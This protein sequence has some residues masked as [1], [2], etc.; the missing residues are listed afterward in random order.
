MIGGCSALCIGPRIVSIVWQGNWL[1][2][3]RDSL[4]ES[5][6]LIKGDEWS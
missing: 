5:M 1:I 4:I 6:K 2:S 3:I